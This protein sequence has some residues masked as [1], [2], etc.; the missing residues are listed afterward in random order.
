MSYDPTGGGCPQCKRLMVLVDWCE[1]NR[2]KCN[3]CKGKDGALDCHN[4]IEKNYC[5][6]CHIALDTEE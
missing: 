2:E 3:W 6:F 5:R 1:E 4:R